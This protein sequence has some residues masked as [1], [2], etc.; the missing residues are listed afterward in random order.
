MTQDEHYMT[1]LGMNACRTVNTNKESNNKYITI[2]H[3]GYE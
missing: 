1:Q 2:L 3:N